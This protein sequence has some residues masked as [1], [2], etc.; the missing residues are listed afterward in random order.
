MKFSS[1]Q[2][3]NIPTQHMECILY[4]KNYKSGDNGNSVVTTENFSLYS[5]Y[6]Y[7]DW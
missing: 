1:E 2:T 5:N 7:E 4:V 6:K 3:V